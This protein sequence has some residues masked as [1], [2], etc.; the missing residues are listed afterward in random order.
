[1]PLTSKGK[2]IMAAMV[3]QYGK[4]KGKEVFYASKNKGTIE[5]VE[6]TKMNYINR[7][8]ELLNERN[9]ENNRRKNIAMG[10]ALSPEA[11]EQR[12]K[13]QHG[14]R[15]DELPG[16]SSRPSNDP[17]SN[18]PRVSGDE[19]GRRRVRGSR[20]EIVNPDGTTQ[21]HSTEKGQ[22]HL[23]DRLM[24]KHGDKLR[25]REDSHTVYKHMG[26][27]MAEALGHRVDEIAKDIAIKTAKN[28]LKNKLAGPKEREEE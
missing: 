18:V 2:K 19:R 28:K 7:V 20:R 15:Q 12:R 3:K 25:A 26:I 23:K 1:M 4:Q 14:T 21:T 6:E 24:A 9:R 8:N 10:R 17:G 22:K 11:A 27:L 16:H 13:E 5:G